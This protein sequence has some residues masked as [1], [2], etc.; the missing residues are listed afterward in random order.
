MP[1]FE[2]KRNLKKEYYLVT[3]IKNLI[4]NKITINHFNIKNFVH[5]GLPTQYE[6]F[7]NWRKLIVEDINKSINLDFQM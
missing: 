5:L 7:K 3:L 6:D 1:P 2:S 4:K